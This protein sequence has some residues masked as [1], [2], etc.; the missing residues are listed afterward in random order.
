MLKLDHPYFLSQADFFFAGDC[1]RL[2]N[3]RACLWRSD[4]SGVELAY[5]MP[6]GRPAGMQHNSK[7]ARASNGGRY[8]KRFCKNGI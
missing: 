6:G 7:L 4:G 1:S 8:K 2:N 3:G 5:E